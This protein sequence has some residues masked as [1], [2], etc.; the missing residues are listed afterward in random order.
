MPEKGNARKNYLVALLTCQSYVIFAYKGE[1][2]IAPARSW[3][4]PKF[5]SGKLELNSFIMR[6]T[7]NVLFS[8]SCQTCFLERHVSTFFQNLF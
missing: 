3:I 5:P 6:G 2:L 7:G 1:R 8:T 4:P